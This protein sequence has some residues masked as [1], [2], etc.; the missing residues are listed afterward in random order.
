MMP[1]SLCSCHNYIISVDEFTYVI[2]CL[3]AG[4]ARAS[5]STKVSSERRFVASANIG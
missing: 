3:R 5:K 4:E 1:F 2:V